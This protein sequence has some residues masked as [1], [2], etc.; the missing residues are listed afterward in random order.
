M[1]IYF[2]FTFLL[3]LNESISIEKMFQ[4]YLLFFFSFPPDLHKKVSLGKDSL[5]ASGHPGY[6][7]NIIID[8]Y[9]KVSTF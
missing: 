2:N 3:T 5:D 4:I 1:V 9:A 6:H 8:P 7:T